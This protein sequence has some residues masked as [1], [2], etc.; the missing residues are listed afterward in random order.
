M[1]VQDK[2]TPE[3][4][5]ET[6]A[7]YILEEQLD[8]YVEYSEKSSCFKLRLPVSALP[9]NISKAVKGC[10]KETVTTFDGKKMKIRM[11]SAS[12]LSGKLL[13]DLRA[14]GESYDFSD[15]VTRMLDDK[16]ERKEELGAEFYKQVTG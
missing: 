1:T 15:W 13:S 11:M 10:T 6:V 8:N 5:A 4:M 3:N 16:K 9:S 7:Q 12:L 2:L 14:L